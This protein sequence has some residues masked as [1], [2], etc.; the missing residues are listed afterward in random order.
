M[1]FFNTRMSHLAGRSRQAVSGR[2]S[3]WESQWKSVSG[4]PAFIMGL[5]GSNPS[6]KEG[7]S[8]FCLLGGTI[9]TVGFQVPR[10]SWL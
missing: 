2:E 10:Q 5:S 3:Q 7:E 9:V 4:V 6:R 1:P 8:I